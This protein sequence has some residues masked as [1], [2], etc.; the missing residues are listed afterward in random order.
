MAYF[1]VIASTL[2]AAHLATFIQ[3]NYS[4]T[5]TPTCKLIRTGI[6][7]TYLVATAE[8]KFVLRV[9]SY[10]WR[11]EIEITEELRF[12]NCLKENK[13][14]VSYPMR[15]KRGDYI[16]MLP[17]PEGIRYAVLFSFAAGK[18]IRN[19]SAETCTNIGLLMARMHRVTLNQK[20]ER[21]NYTAYTLT[22]LPYTYALAH[23]PEY[24]PEMQFLQNAKK[25]LTLLFDEVDIHTIRTGI[26]HLDMWYDNMNIQDEATIT[27]FD[28]DFCG[29]G[30]LLLDIAYFVMQ[31]L[32]TE[33]DKEIYKAKLQS[34]YNGYQEVTP[35]SDEEKR[36]L[37]YAGLAIWIFYLGVQC[38][39]F[40]NWS[41]I[42]LTENYLKHYISMVK[43][44]M[45]FNDI[46]FSN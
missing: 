14:N 36:L 4:F 17:A 46:E 31:L 45:Q 15:D 35:I 41:N 34:F 11:T 3:E 38:Q 32:N 9:Y 24:L 40:N 22:H 39:R 7:H 33:P 43:N 42:F 16:Q 18:K 26:V 27:L 8:T 21:I 28:F 5:S 23:F 30:W 12:L 37:P 25:S 1:P 6:N 20:V 19:L 29:N 13:I 44:W 10:L 2:S